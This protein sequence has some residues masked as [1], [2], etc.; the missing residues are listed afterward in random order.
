MS[1]ETARRPRAALKRIAGTFAAL[2][3]TVSTLLATGSA[4]AGDVT[5]QAN[6]C[7]SSFVLIDVY[8]GSGGGHT[9]ELRLY[10]SST[11]EQNCAVM[12]KTSDTGHKDQVGVQIRPTG[13]SVDPSGGVD[14]G[15][16]YQYAGPVYTDNRIDMSNRCVDVHGFVG[17]AHEVFFQIEKRGVHCG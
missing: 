4:A 14:N 12:M 10:W 3:L 1:D 15:W 16:F 8:R 17:G 6:V 9:A 5:S 11:Y 2:I 13:G 7:G